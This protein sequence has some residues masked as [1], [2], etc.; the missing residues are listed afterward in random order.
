MVLRYNDNE[1]NKNKIDE[2][3]G[4]DLFHDD[5]NIVFE[6]MIEHLIQAKNHKK[7]RPSK[8]SNHIRFNR[9]FFDDIKKCY[10]QVSVDKDNV[11]VKTVLIFT[12]GKKSVVSQTFKV[13]DKANIHIDKNMSASNCSPTDDCKFVGMFYALLKANLGMGC[14]KDNVINGNGFIRKYSTFINNISKTIPATVQ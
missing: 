11:R 5:C 4:Y 7:R 12:D 8:P 13:T 1:R 2:D 14:N 9:Y 3:F 6:S 10:Y